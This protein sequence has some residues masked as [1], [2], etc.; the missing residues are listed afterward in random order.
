MSAQSPVLRTTLTDRLSIID[1]LVFASSTP[2]LK[3]AHPR[4][5]LDRTADFIDPVHR[6]SRSLRPRK[7]V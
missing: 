3:D 5:W 7:L 2:V 6:S 1:F 4:P